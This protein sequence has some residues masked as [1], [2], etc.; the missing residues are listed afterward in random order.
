[1][2]SLI[3]ATGVWLVWASG[4]THNTHNIHL[5]SMEEV[6][7]VN[8][9]D[10]A[11]G[12]MEKLEA[13]R[14]G[15]LHRAFSIMIFND[16]GEVL[17]QRR[18]LDKYHSP[19]LWTNACCSHP[20]PG[21]IL[22]AAAHRRL[23]EELGFDCELEHSFHFIYKVQ[24]D[25]DLYEHELDHVFEGTYN[26][27]PDFNPAEVAEVKFFKVQELAELIKIYPEWY[28]EWFKMIWMA[29][30]AKGLLE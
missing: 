28:T 18:A 20:R 11:I 1:M 7:L 10:E 15:V 2:L 30:E 12:T 27:L 22:D 5:L 21:E 4:S 23:Q 6:I 26:P 24:F 16:Q 14:K 25:N 17:L 9:Q 3:L 19:G 29:Y 8:E 13:H